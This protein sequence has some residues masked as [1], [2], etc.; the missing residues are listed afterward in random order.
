VPITQE[1]IDSAGAA[2]LQEAPLVSQNPHASEEVRQKIL[3]YVDKLGYEPSTELVVRFALPIE[4]ELQEQKARDDEQARRQAERE[5]RIHRDMNL[6]SSVDRME[7]ISEFKTR[8][9]RPET[10]TFTPVEYTQAE[11]DA[12][13]EEEAQAAVFGKPITDLNRSVGPAPAGKK[14]GRNIKQKAFDAR[15]QE[16]ENVRQAREKEIA[17][18][19]AQRAKLRADLK[20]ALNK[21]GG[22]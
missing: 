12:M 6:P 1:F 19:K 17:F 22:Q 7:A 9:L 5:A 14:R 10:H 20:A 8:N 11:I 16:E 15:R 3:S 21:T 4:K 2:L 13:S 18:D